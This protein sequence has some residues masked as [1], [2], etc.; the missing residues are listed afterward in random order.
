MNKL[1]A[2]GTSIAM[3]HMT[4]RTHENILY[5][6]YSYHDTTQTLCFVCNKIITTHTYFLT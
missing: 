4:Y 5:C 2:I 1:Q 3:L 6:L